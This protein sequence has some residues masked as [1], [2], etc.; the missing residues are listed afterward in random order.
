MFKWAVLEKDLEDVMAN[1]CSRLWDMSKDI[2]LQ[3]QKKGE[4]KSCF[5]PLG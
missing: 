1:V 3:R 2:I 4:R 5:K